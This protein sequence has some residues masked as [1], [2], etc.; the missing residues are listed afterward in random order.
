V[1]TV[2]VQKTAS[3]EETVGASSWQ[4]CLSPA[5]FWFPDRLVESSWLEHAPFAF[6]LIDVLRPGL[7]VELGTHR[8]FSYFTFC[9]AVDRLGIDARCYAVDTWRGDEH[10]GFY[11][12]DIFDEFR[13]Y[14][15]NRFG[16]FSRLLRMTFEEAVSC[17]EDESIDLLHIDGRHFYQDVRNEFES[18]KSKLSKRSVVLFHDTNVREREFGVFKLWSELSENYPAFEFVHGHGLGIIAIGRVTPAPLQSLFA[19]AAV[20]ADR[21]NIR[22]AYARLGATVKTAVEL[23]RA[24]AEAQEQARAVDLMKGSTCWRITAPLRSGFVQSIYRVL[25]EPLALLSRK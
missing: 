23:S 21:Q 7:L 3:L 22:S 4:T 16:H 6:W 14:H 13:S 20:A 1:R 17:F 11:G 8:G 24:V 9:Q 5:S 15:D 10:T 19:S 18:W 12:D 2:Q 25:R